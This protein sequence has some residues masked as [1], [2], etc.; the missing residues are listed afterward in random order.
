[1]EARL[2]IV[3]ES[4]QGDGTVNDFELS[5]SRPGAFV[6]SRDDLEAGETGG[7]ATG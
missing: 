2:A 5:L 3:V 7:N 4:G 6:C 1:M